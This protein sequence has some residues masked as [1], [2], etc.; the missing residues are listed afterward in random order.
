MN[1]QYLTTQ[2]ASRSLKLPKETVRRLCRDGVLVGAVQDHE[3]GPWRIPRTSIEAWQ[4]RHLSNK[5]EFEGNE[6]PSRWQRFRHNPFVFYPALLLSALFTISAFVFGAISAGADLGTATEQLQDWGLVH[7]FPVSSEE[8][9]LII[10]MTFHYPEGIPNTEPHEKIKRSIAQQV[11]ALGFSYVRVEVEPR[12]LTQDERERARNI[13]EDYGAKMIIW[14]EDTGVELIVNYLS[15]TDHQATYSEV[16]ILET[17]ESGRTLFAHP[18]AYA[19]LVTE[20]L[21]LISTFLSLITI[22]HASF[23]SDKYDD[24]II[25][26]QSAITSAEQIRGSK[27]DGFP[28]IL[29]T[30][31]S[32]LNIAHLVTKSY[33]LALDDSNELIRLDPKDHRGYLYSGV[34]HYFLGHNDDAIADYTR[35]IERNPQASD[36]YNNRGLVYQHLERYTDAIADYTRVVEIKPQDPIS[37]YHRGNGYF[38]QNE[39]GNA[40]SDYTRAIELAPQDSTAY[41]GRGHAYEVLGEFEKAI[42]D[43]SQAMKLDPQNWMPYF[44]RG[45]VYSALNKHKDAIVDYTRAAKLDPQNKSVYLNRGNSYNDLGRYEDAI[46]DYTRDIELNPQNNKAY[47]YRGGTYAKLGRR[48]EALSDFSRVIDLEPE[49]GAA[50]FVRGVGFADLGDHESAIVDYT[51]AIELAPN[52]AVAYAARG[53]SRFSLGEYEIA[54]DDFTRAI[55]LDPQNQNYYIAR[56]NAFTELGNVLSA[57]ADYARAEELD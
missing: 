43:Y 32:T 5:G 46:A 56:G 2:E 28:E 11:A 31:L 29:F 14:G 49:N 22:G 37:Y 18:E 13:A 1:K 17:G 40:I 23:E 19:Q 45:N 8:E 47:T 16:Q 6:P 57:N 38:A 35:A 55:D 52:N 3:N 50:Y 48:E 44:N 42:S 36:A 51:R 53:I 24:S 20:D 30:S 4:N 9:T 41:I 27:P 7:A 15:P 39:Y 54:I 12:A 25:A 26:I 34:A 10:V 21:P 33:D